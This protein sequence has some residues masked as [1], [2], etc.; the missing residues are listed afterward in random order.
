MLDRGIP[1][2]LPYIFNEKPE[3][4]SDFTGFIQYPNCVSFAGHTLVGAPPLYGGYEYTPV[5]INKKDSISLYNK[6]REAYLLLPRIFSN[7]GYTVTINDPPFDS[8]LQS[9]LGIFK[10]YPEIQAEN[11][12]RKYSSYWLQKH[13][14]ISGLNITQVLKNN[15]IRFSFFKMSP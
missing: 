8:Y 13:P 1:G 4:L 9:N 5:E 3:L 7:Q 6:H 14:G 2:C 10:D 12:I 11:I 15:L